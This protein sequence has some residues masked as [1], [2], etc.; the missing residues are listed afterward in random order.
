MT[1]DN[2]AVAM[3]PV[4]TRRPDGRQAD[5]NDREAIRI[6]LAHGFCSAFLPESHGGDGPNVCAANR[7]Y[8]RRVLP[9]R[10]PVGAAS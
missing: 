10:M 6:A 3:I 2:A 8:L 4:P 5:I 1:Q 9:R 7:Q